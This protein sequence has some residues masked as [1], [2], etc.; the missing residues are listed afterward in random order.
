LKVIAGS[1]ERG[2]AIS[3]GIVVAAITVLAMAV[4]TGLP[5]KNVAPAVC[6]VVGI[7]I[8]YRLA[9]DWRSLLSLTIMVIL[10]IP[11]RRYVLPINLPFE[12]EPYRLVVAFTSLGWFIS[13]L[14]DPRV[15]LRKSG[16]AGPLYLITISELASVILNPTAVSSTEAHVV[17][18]LS[19]FG[20]FVLVFFLIVSVIRTHDQIDGLVKV[21]VGSGAVI[22]FFALIEAN[23]GYNVFNHLHTFIPF[24]REG[25]VPEIPTRGGRLRTYASAEH[26][27][28]LGAMLVMLVPLAA[29]LARRLRQ[30]RWWF[31]AGLLL[32]GALATVSRTS[33]LMLA[34]VAIVFLW[35]RPKQMRRMWPALVPMLLVVH[36]ALPGTIGTLKQSF[37]PKGGLIKEQSANPGWHG[38]GRLAD[39]GPS[40]DK[41][42]TK[43]LFG[44]GFGTRITD[45]LHP[46]SPILDDQWLSTLVETG[47]AGFAAWLWLFLRA[48]RRFG[49]EA[50]RDHSHRGWLLA[51]ITGST[52]AFA[53][54]MITY[55]A[56]SFTQVTFLLFIELAL[57]VSLL[58]LP[59]PDDEN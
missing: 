53:I 14:V 48:I 21:L 39:V 33:M 56:F 11:I 54:G 49:L 28:E 23:T 36:M 16:F 34:C 6:V 27:I 45:G 2:P 18:Q 20:S 38:S 44:Q 22:S 46:N 30:R 5:V 4:F 31:A 32:L 15:R 50:K 10:F 40:I 43:P 42:K 59:R 24:L 47:L 51:G 12:F 41:V 3:A 7:A 52:L 19:Y 25:Y 58:R 17:K 9:L 55:D 35:L 1:G 26:A 57:A 13:L 37:F 29:Y 8:G